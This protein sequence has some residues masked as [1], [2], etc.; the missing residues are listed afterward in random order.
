MTLAPLGILASSGGAPAFY[1]LISTQVLGSNA[2][3]VTFSSIPQ[4]YSHLQLRWVAQT[5][6]NPSVLRAR[7]NSDSTGAN[8]T[9]HYF[10]T[11]GS[12]VGSVGSTS[13]G[14]SEMGPLDVGTNTFAVGVVDI[15]DYSKTSKNKTTRSFAAK[16]GSSNPFIYLASSLWISTAAITQIELAEAF[17]GQNLLTGSRFS[18]YGIKG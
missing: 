7:F 9:R 10:Y 18:L 2:S 11:D 4:T 5:N 8:Y 1:E 13:Q 6:S 12:S 15:L 17:Y 16:R 3:S 14:W